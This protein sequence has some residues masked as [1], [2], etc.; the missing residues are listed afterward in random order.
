MRIIVTGGDGFCGWPTS[1]RLARHGHD[2]VIVDN[3][4]RRSIDIELGTTSV[5]PISSI[6][7]RVKKASKSIGSVSFRNIDVDTGIDELRSLIFEYRPDAIIHFAEQRSAP[8]SMIGHS[9][10]RY[11]IQNNIGGTQNIC[12]AIADSGLD[13]H[14]V[15]LGTM[16]VYGY[17]QA[18]GEIPEGYL[19]VCIKQTKNDASILYPANPGSIY[20][21]SKCLDQ[22]IFQFYNKNW[23]IRITDL[24]QGIVWGTQTEETRIDEDLINRFDYDGVFGTVLNRFVSQAAVGE[25]LSV[26][27]EGGQKRAFIHI[28]DTAT[29]IQ[30]AVED[31]DFDKSKVRI[32]NQVSEVQSVEYLAKLIAG[33]FEADIKY[34]PNPR[35]ELAANELQVSN[36]GLKNLGFEPTTLSEG[37]LN[38]IKEITTKFSCK[39]DLTKILNSP[40]W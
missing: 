13:I 33:I 5:T 8:Y 32:F 36:Q 30:M 12:S 40:K 15:H 25:P 10:R 3:L 14:L 34:Y 7:K 16:G 37:L 24:H 29:C 35:K 26:Y 21:L 18:F 2:V 1:L 39:L 20:H 23:G 28:S 19:D 17:N 27:G 11:T 22:L 9:H 4:V 38:E 6:E 31:N